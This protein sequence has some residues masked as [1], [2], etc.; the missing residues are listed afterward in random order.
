M[1]RIKEK[2]TSLE[3]LRKKAGKEQAFFEA[4]MKNPLKALKLQHLTLS[5]EDMRQL[6]HLIEWAK[7]LEGKPATEGKMIPLSIAPPP[8]WPAAK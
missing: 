6:R 5:D 3:S 1:A 4:L 7:Y 2:K 8:P